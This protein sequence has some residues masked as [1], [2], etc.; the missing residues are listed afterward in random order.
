[1]PEVSI[2]SFA[3][4]VLPRSNIAQIGAQCKITSLPLITPRSDSTEDA[5]R[6]FPLARAILLFCLLIFT[7][8]CV[9]VQQPWA[10][11]FFEIGTL[12]LVV[13]C[14]VWD[15]HG[16]K[17]PLA[18]GWTPWLVYLIPVWGLFQLIFHTTVSSF[19]TRGEFLKWA[20]LASIFFVAQTISANGRF[21]RIA[22]DAFVFFASAMA[23]LCVLQL[24][25]S[26]GRILWLFDSGYPDVYAT[27]PY[28][29]NYAQFVELALPVAL[30]RFMRLGWRAWG[31]AFCAGILYAS[32]IG[33]S[34][35]AG[36]A[37]CTGELIVISIVGLL[38]LRGKHTDN[39]QKAAP[40]VLLIIP[41]LALIFTAVIG[42]QTLWGRF[43]AGDPF[44]GRREFVIAA[45]DM[46]KHRP[47]TGYGLGTFPEVYQQHA[48]RDFP[49]Y[50]NHTHCDWAEFAADGGIP[51]LLLV[52][53][54]F[55][56]AVPAA[57]RH[58]WGIGVVA[59]LLHACVDYP[60][61]RPAVS[62]WLFALLAMLYMAKRS[63]ALK[64]EERQFADRERQILQFSRK[65]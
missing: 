8:G 41:V 12:A 45:I 40:A 60:F 1:V 31:F 23:L 10:V 27:F 17:E 2:V 54:P 51:F 48:I 52:L 42:W 18:R 32:V 49:F 25:T 22:L 20:A 50:A 47:L 53:V 57:F 36:A 38:E 65:G 29:N 24:F 44:S 59:V 64:S 28:H 33:S 63:D 9:F 16:E 55:V 56:M 3:G 46:A 37:L 14:L 35:R 43:K 58:P 30:W 61:P 6:P 15:I 13:G 5:S 19:E 21:R 26:D 7:T 39:A 4:A 11:L 34:S 62:G